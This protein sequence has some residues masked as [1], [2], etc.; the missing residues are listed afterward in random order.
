LSVIAPKVGGLVESWQITPQIADE[1]AKKI[2]LIN[3]L[4]TRSQYLYCHGCHKYYISIYA[5]EK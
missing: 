2:G 1:F 3:F 4:I 5:R